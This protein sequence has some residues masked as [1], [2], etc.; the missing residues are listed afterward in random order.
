MPYQNLPAAVAD[1]QGSGLCSPARIIHRD[2]KPGNILSLIP[3]ANV[4]DFVSRKSL[5]LTKQST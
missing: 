5:S 3:R 2:I 1:C 4:A